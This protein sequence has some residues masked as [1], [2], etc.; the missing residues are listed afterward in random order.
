M[1]L[2]T[3][4]D[5]PPR[6][7][8]RCAALQDALRDPLSAPARWTNPEQFHVTIRFLGATEPEQARRYKRALSQLEAPAARCVPYGLDVL[9]SRRTP[10]VVILGLE[11][12]ETLLTLYDAVSD[13]LEAEGLA[14]EDRPYRPH[15]TLA[16]LD[17]PDP[18]RVHNAL[19]AID[20]AA[21]DPFRADTL[22]LYE[23]TRTPEGA[24][25]EQRA[26][27]GLNLPSS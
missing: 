26:S 27:I 9:P 17:D 19:K 22:F 13:A 23:S 20:D 6:V 24:V 25:H 5:P 3:A 10:R 15:L 14:S 16:R 12:T 4:L 8:S 2:F 7:R 21:I 18:E 11:R 1:R